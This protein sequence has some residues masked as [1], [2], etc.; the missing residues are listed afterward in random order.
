MT[1]FALRRYLVCALCAVLVLSVAGSAAA[2][3]PFDSDGF[4]AF[5]I[6]S[7][8]G[9]ADVD[10]VVWT[11]VETDPIFHT[12]SS[13]FGG[14]GVLVYMEYEPV[15][16][17]SG[18]LIIDLRHAGFPDLLESNITLPNR[19][20]AEIY[21]Q[22][23]SGAGDLFESSRVEGDVTIVEIYRGQGVSAL[24]LRFDLFALG[25]SDSW[26]RVVGSATTS[27]T[28]EQ[29]VLLERDV[30]YSRRDRGEVYAPDGDI[31]VDCYGDAHVV[32]EEYDEETYYYED[33]DGGGCSGDTWD[34][35]VEDPQES[36]GCAGETTVDDGE[37]DPD[38][39]C[40]G[41]GDGLD[42]D[43][44]EEDESWYEND[45]Y[46]DGESSGCDEDTDT[47][48]ESS[49]SSDC[50][51]DTVEASIPAGEQA[52]LRAYLAGMGGSRHKRQLAGAAG[53]HR[54]E[55]DTARTI[56]RLCS[57]LPFFLVALGIRAAR[58]RL[59]RPC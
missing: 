4:A 56:R 36:G 33:D 27:L 28:V 14:G 49:S 34:D 23:W 7:G 37:P 15:D 10:D 5:R 43:E 47:D 6:A 20:R 58:R 42:P 32:E 21:Y 50:E 2:F 24:G 26:R 29:A 48:D 38:G 59:R 25:A 45:D 52:R 22:E 30:V 1:S 17:H 18:L 3:A 46:S 51:G 19:R 11:A 16:G 44:Y 31:Y 9:E 12:L 55:A 39:G 40:E 41:S 57:Y 53:F 13:R 8:A 54:F 35:D